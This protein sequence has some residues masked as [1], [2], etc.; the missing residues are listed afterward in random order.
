M[1]IYIDCPARLKGLD[2]VEDYKDKRMMQTEFLD[3]LDP[4]DKKQ[5]TGRCYQVKS[6]MT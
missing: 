5:R 6:H 2:T 1:P 4:M 3:Q